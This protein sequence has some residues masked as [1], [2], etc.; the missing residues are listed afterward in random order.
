[1]R[2]RFLLS[3]NFDRHMRIRHRPADLFEK[4]VTVPLVNDSDSPNQDVRD[5]YRVEIHR[6]PQLNKKAEFK[7]YFKNMDATWPLVDRA[8]VVVKTL[9]NVMH[10]LSR[11]IPPHSQCRLMLMSESLDRAVNLPIMPVSEISSRHLFY[12]ITVV[13]QNHFEVD[14]NLLVG[15]LILVRPPG[16]GEGFPR[17][18]LS[19]INSPKP[20][21]LRRW[22]KN[23]RNIISVPEN[24]DGLCG[25]RAL[26]GALDLAKGGKET[27]NYVQ[28]ISR[29]VRDVAKNLHLNTPLLPVELDY[30][31]CRSP[32][33]FEDYELN[34][35]GTSVDRKRV[36]RSPLSSS[37]KLNLL[38]HLGH[39]YVLK[40]VAKFMEKKYYCSDCDIS[41]DSSKHKFCTQCF[42]Y[43]VLIHVGYKT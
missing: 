30:V 17:G 24:E 10:G 40:N 1:M 28:H 7:L 4:S 16:A 15:H 32:D 29:R 37:K 42:V 12:Y 43:N 27:K 23:S 22:I 39:Y 3:D 35:Y 5:Y 8:W 13:L 14:I 18:N 2:T 25:L 38:I 21:C 19:P 9:E 33:L 6:F 34:V 11:S 41:Y 20:T 31:M 36:Y 26:F